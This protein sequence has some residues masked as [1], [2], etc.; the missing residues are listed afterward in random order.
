MNFALAQEMH[1]VLIL[2]EALRLLSVLVCWRRLC[3][4]DM[5]SCFCSH[6]NVITYFTV[7]AVYLMENRLV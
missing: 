6:G 7:F 4:L 1:E 3:G 2:C 5:C